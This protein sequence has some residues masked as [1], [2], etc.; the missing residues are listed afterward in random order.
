MFAKSI[1][2]VFM[3]LIFTVLA[4]SIINLSWGLGIITLIVMLAASIG[5]IFYVKNRS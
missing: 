2:F 4:V 5:I 1:V 3:L